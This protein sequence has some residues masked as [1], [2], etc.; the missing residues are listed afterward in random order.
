MAYHSRPR[1]TEDIDILVRPSEE[2]AARMEAV[3]KPFGFA[4]LG[5]N[6]ADFLR[7]GQVVQLGYP[8]NRIDLM[9]GISGVSFEEAWASRQFGELD[10]VPV[11]FLDRE[12]L[13][14][15]KSAAGRGKDLE[16]VKRLG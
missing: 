11:P 1:H 8:P 7:E 14:K 16:D 3:L 4:S 9:T 12:C 13:V 15:N 6:A 10:G 2:N 5:L